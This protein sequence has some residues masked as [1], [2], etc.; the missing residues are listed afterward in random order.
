V[1]DHLTEAKRRATRAEGH[2]SSYIAATTPE[3]T[4]FHR[5]MALI[6]SNLATAHATIATAEA[7]Q[8]PAGACPS[9]YT[10]N[11]LGAEERLYCRFP[12]DHTGLHENDP[13][14]TTSGETVSRWTSEAE[15]VTRL[16]Q[17]QP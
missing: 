9:I 16:D 10:I 2:H 8:Q 13:K 11:F 15:G 7:T 6:E 5:T 3:D 12:Y 17:E 1:T 4:E 14:Y